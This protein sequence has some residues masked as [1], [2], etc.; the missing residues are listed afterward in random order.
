[1]IASQKQ[2][3]IPPQVYTHIDRQTQDDYKVNQFDMELCSRWQFIVTAS[4]FI[5]LF[6]VQSGEQFHLRHW[7]FS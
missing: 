1:M 6:F 7:R 3:K 2:I 5:Q 4:L